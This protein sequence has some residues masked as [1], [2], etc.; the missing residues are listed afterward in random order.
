M[1]EPRLRIA[2]LGAT[3]GTGRVFM[4]QALELGHSIT[5]IVRTPS[6]LAVQHERLQVA[7][8]DVRDIE[9]LAASFG[10]HD[11]V[12]AMFGTTDFR[13]A[14]KASDLYSTGGRNIIAAMRATQV[15][16]LVIVSSSGVLYDPNAPFLWNRV[17]RPMFWR[18]YADMSQMELLVSESDLEWT[19]VRP[20]QLTNDLPTGAIAAAADSIPAG[21]P[22]LT[23]G[24]L[25]DFLLEELEDPQFIRQ[26]P[27][28]AG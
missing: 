18:I 13:N 6:K 14:M 23:R 4:D 27:V 24:D 17:L 8:G 7:Q 26:R 10:G 19:I 11:A 3:G 9:T 2:L 25:A 12:A 1:S 21:Q 20:P 5:A 16:R 15:R 22:K 28:L